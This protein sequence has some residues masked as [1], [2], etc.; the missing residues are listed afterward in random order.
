MII[1]QILA[2]ILVFG[3]V[4][5]IH[6]L[7]HFLAAKWSGVRVNEFAMGMGPKLFG[8]TRGET[9]YCLRLLPIGGAC[10]ME[11]EDE[12]SDDGRSFGKAK[13]WK[14]IIIIVAGAVMNL[15]LGFLLL[16]GVTLAT[17]EPTALTR[18]VGGVG[19]VSEAGGLRAG[20]EIVAIDGRKM[21]TVNELNYELYII[22]D[23]K[24]DVTVLRDGKKIV[25]NDVQLRC[26]VV[27]DDGTEA[28]RTNFWV[29]EVENTTGRSLGEAAKMPI[30]TTRTIY[31]TLADMITGRVPLKEASG[32]VG[33]IEATAQATKMGFSSVLNLM[34]IISINLG[35]FNLLPLPAL[36]GGRL[37]FLLFEAVTRKR[38][39][40]KYEAIVHAVGLILLFGLI[41][42]VTFND[43]ARCVT[44]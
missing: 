31:R 1:L 40:P 18:T 36:D 7:G 23:Q 2:V 33:I 20:D 37:V 43:I 14:R 41:I 11:G 42:L 25:L 3:G 22:Q 8:F 32:P 27:N 34:A 9:T 38:L 6:E 5:F 35:V 28:L 39:K 24:V 26:W 44:G 21:Y 10:V 29:N 16:F 12:E 4:I 30:S 13:I 17:A 15:A 19:S